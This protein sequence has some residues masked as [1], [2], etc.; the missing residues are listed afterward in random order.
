MILVLLVLLKDVVH[1]MKKLF[2]RGLIFSLEGELF[3]AD[4]IVVGTIEV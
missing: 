2:L 4:E 1:A 3:V